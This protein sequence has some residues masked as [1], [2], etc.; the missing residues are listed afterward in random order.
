M[1]RNGSECVVGV[2]VRF[3]EYGNS[4]D[5]SGYDVINVVVMVVMEVME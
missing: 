3:L 2:V 5:D 4:V 1:R